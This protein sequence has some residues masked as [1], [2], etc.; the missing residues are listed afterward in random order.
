MLLEN[1]LSSKDEKNAFSMLGISLHKN[2]EIFEKEKEAKELC[3]RIVFSILEEERKNYN[4][5]EYKNLNNKF[6]EIKD[7][8]EK[9]NKELEIFLNLIT[10][11]NKSIIELLEEISPN[12]F[13]PINK[14][15]LRSLLFQYNK[16]R[17]FY[18]TKYIEK[19]EIFFK[20]TPSASFELFQTKYIHYFQVHKD[21][22]ETLEQVKL[23]IIPELIKKYET[24]I[25]QTLLDKPL[26]SQFEL[27]LE[28]NPKYRDIHTREIFDQ[29]FNI[30]NQNITLINSNSTELIRILNVEKETLIDKIVKRNSSI[31]E[32]NN[33]ELKETLES[34]FETILNWISNNIKK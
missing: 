22:K 28:K 15:K 33:E 18:L 7:K 12:R 20:D 17:N 27:F 16:E 32:G 10:P 23:E 34:K 9:N 30:I 24:K 2:L 26:N 5:K 14:D 11:L 29:L 3:I 19:I 8:F 25:N 6:Q 1:Y 21:L 31:Q 4:K 13:S